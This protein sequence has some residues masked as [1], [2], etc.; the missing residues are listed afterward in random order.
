VA[1]SFGDE[2]AVDAALGDHDKRVTL[3]AETA[4]GELSNVTPGILVRLASH[5]R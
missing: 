1:A 2:T 5:K 4:A 3:A